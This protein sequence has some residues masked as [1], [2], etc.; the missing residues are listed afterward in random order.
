MAI[1]EQIKLLREQKDL[2]RYELAEKIGVSY[3]TI[4][5]YETGERTPPSDIIEKL[6]DFF[7]VTTDYLLGR[8]TPP[9]R[10]RPTEEEKDHIRR[11][12]HTLSEEDKTDILREFFDW[13]MRESQKEN[14]HD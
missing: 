4:A 12:W 13:K 9:A 5:K 2:D 11:L 6:A 14:K 8:D 3:H 1:G 7:E 10:P